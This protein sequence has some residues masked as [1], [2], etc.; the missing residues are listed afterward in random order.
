[1][2]PVAPHRAIRRL[3]G[4]LPKNTMKSFFLPALLFAMAFLVHLT[5]NIFG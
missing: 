1:M 3:D 5:P 2:A 4:T